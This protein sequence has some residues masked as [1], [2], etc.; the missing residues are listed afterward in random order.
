MWCKIYFKFG[1]FNVYLIYFDKLH[2]GDIVT[3]GALLMILKYGQ[4]I[5]SNL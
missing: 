5:I 3:E 1:N 4:E 2:Y